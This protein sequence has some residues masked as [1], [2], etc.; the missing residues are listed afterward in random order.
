MGEQLRKNWQSIYGCLIKVGSCVTEQQYSV[1]YLIKMTIKE[2][3][4]INIGSLLP[5]IS[6]IQTHPQLFLL[7]T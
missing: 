2:P 1:T 7:N 6:V 4:H 3:I 5:E